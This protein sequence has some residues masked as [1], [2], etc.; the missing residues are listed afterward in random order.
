VQTDRY[1]IQYKSKVDNKVSDALSRRSHEDQAGQLV[2][3]REILSTWFYDLKSSY[4]NGPC[5]ASVLDGSNQEKEIT[6]YNGV[7]KKKRRIYV[8]DNNS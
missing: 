3:I 5:A 4:E 6:I 2:A 8:G 7:I 1:I